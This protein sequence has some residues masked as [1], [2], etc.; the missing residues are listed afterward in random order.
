MMIVTPIRS[1]PR[2]DVVEIEIP[3]PPMGGK[4]W[5]LE[6]KGL[7][8]LQRG[9]GMLRTIACT[10]AGAGALEAID[11]VPD[12][13]GFFPDR[14]LTEFTTVDGDQTRNMKFYARNGRP[15]YRATSAIMGSFMLD[16]GFYHGL[17]IRA[18]GGHQSSSAIAS[19]VWMPVRAKE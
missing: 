1:A 19:I 10:H 18:Q 2:I 15:I 14:E 5:L 16:G 17:T 6:S 7:F 13:D 11:G 4:I 8:I 12:N 9:P 3:T